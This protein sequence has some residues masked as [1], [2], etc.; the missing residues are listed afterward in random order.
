MQ[1][2]AKNILFYALN[3]VR[4]A[5]IRFGLSALLDCFAMGYRQYFVYNLPRFFSPLRINDRLI[6]LMGEVHV[7]IFLGSKR[8][9]LGFYHMG[10]ARIESKHELKTGEVDF[11]MYAIS[12]LRQALGRMNKE[13]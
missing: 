6:F 1:N 13:Y 2:L 12:N 5:L 8:N 7:D 3:L 9:N 10:M 4:T 11:C